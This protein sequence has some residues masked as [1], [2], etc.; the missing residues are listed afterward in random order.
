MIR[1]NSNAQQNPATAKPFN[2]FPVSKIIKESITNMNKPKV[3]IVTGI[4]KKTMIGFK[5]VL[6]T[7]NTRTTQMAV[8]KFLIDMPGRIR[9]AEYTATV[10]INNFKKRLNITN[11][12]LI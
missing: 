11:A 1:P 6:R 2:I 9:A 10:E 7:A 5:N 8:P 3:I 12:P 4:D